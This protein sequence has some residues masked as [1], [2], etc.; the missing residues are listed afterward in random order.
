MSIEKLSKTEEELLVKGKKAAAFNLFSTNPSFQE[1]YRREGKRKRINGIS[2]GSFL[3]EPAMQSAA[4]QD[5][6]A[7]TFDRTHSHSPKSFYYKIKKK[8]RLQCIALAGRRAVQTL[9]LADLILAQGSN[10]TS[11]CLKGFF[12]TLLFSN[13]CMNV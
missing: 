6:R 13:V 1:K 7:L 11:Q 10:L 12:L 9:S 5:R 4:A 8:G 2:H 3:S